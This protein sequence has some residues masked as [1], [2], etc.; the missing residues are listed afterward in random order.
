M[1]YRFGQIVLAFVVKPIAMPVDDDAERHGI[2][3]R[4]DAAVELRGARIDG[5]RMTLRW[6]ADRLRTRDR[7]SAAA[8]VPVLYGVP[9]MM[10]FLG[11][12]APDLLKPLEIRF[13]AAGAARTTVRARSPCCHRPSTA[14]DSKCPSRMHEP[15]D[16]RFVRD[17]TPSRSAAAY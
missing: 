1:A 16:L 17:A 9:R 10:K 15:D 7:A 12:V 8:R 5:D 11:G 13:E 14:A 3:P 2:E 6:I 4:H